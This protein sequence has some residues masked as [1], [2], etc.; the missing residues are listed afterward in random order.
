[1]DA[2]QPEPPRIPTRVL[3][4]DTVINVAQLLLEPVGAVRLLQLKLDWLAL[5]EDMMAR[6]IEAKVQLLRISDGLIASGDVQGTAIVECVRCLEDYDQP[7]Q[8][9]FDQQYRPLIDIQSGMLADYGE[10]AGSDDEALDIDAVHELDL[11]EPLRQVAIVSLPMNP[12]CG[13]GCPGPDVSPDNDEDDGDG[14][15]SILAQLLEDAPE[16][17]D[18]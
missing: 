16:A 4:N 10:L 15:L 9:S 18:S 11:A 6:D 8:A 12:S 3:V 2:K 13:P 7:F 5:D 1:V 17:V 14:R